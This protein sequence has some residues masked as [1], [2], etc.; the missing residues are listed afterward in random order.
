[1]SLALAKARIAFIVG[2]PLILLGTPLRW[3]ESGVPLCPIKFFFGVDC[4]GCGMTRAFWSVLHLDLPLAWHYNRG[5]IV[6][7]PIIA[8]AAARSL[9]RDWREVTAKEKALP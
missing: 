6:V 9:L 5:V 1:M 3:L 4:P 8:F 7:F 2:V